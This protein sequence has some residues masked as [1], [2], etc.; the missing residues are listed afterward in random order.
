MGGIDDRIL[1][2]QKVNVLTEKG[3][4]P[5]VVGSKPPHIQKEEER[6]KIVSYDEM[7]STSA[8][9]TVKTPKLWA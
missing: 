9:K 5:G 8:R 1:L 4:L 3:A 2:A 6:K 7:F